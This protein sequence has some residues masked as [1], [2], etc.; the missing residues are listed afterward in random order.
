MDLFSTPVT[1]YMHCN[2]SILVDGCCNGEPA[3]TC[4]GVRMLLLQGD[5]FAG[6]V[7]SVEE[8]SGEAGYKWSERC[9]GINSGAVKWTAS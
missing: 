4:A 1:R 7:A 2:G 6:R 8:E 3:K 9:E 5:W